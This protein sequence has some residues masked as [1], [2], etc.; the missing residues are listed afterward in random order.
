MEKKIRL[1]ER[2]LVMKEFTKKSARKVRL[3]SYVNFMETKERTSPSSECRF[4]N[5]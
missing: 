1:W 2:I 4:E 3:I 5:F